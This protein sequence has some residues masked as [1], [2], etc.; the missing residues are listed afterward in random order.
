MGPDNAA[1]LRL[2]GKL[3]GKD[4]LLA[5]HRVAHFPLAVVVGLETEAALADWRRQAKI[6]ILGGLLAAVGI[7]IVFF[8]IVRQLIRSHERARRRLALEKLRFATAVNNMTQGL[9]LF[10]AS[11]RIVITNQRYV[12]MYGL[13][14]DVVKEGCLFRD[15]ILHRKEKGTFNGD[16][17][18]YHSQLRSELSHGQAT[19]LITHPPDG[20]SIRIIKNQPI[21][22]GGW[23]STHEDITASKRAAERIV[24][25][26]S[27]TI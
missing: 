9:I 16:V 7:V 22:G 2:I 27:A 6:F 3:D 15:L 4:R 23:L 20:R 11:E 18:E 17:E 1:T 10:D 24:H 12:D 14:P 8:L 13:S 26:P 19:E 5:T 21:A 25:W